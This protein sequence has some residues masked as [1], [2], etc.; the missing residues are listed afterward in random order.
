MNVVTAEYEVIDVEKQIV[1]NVY[2]VDGEAVAK[3]TYD[4]ANPENDK[5]EGT[6]VEYALSQGFEWDEE[7]QNRFHEVKREEAKFVLDMKSR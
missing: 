5:T 1:V 4:F 3:Y 2:R 7:K 6:I